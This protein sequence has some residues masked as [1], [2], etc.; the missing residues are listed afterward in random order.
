MYPGHQHGYQGYQQGGYD[1][2]QAHPNH[3]SYQPPS[4][5]PPGPPPG[6]PHH[7]NH[8]GNEQQNP[9]YGGYQDGYG[10]G[11]HYN[12][13]PVDHFSQ[14]ETIEEG[15]PIYQRPPGP[16]PVTRYNQLNFYTANTTSYVNDDHGS[17]IKDQMV[18]CVLL[19][20]A[21]VIQVVEEP[22][23]LC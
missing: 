22:R 16:P 1:G 7:H 17:L 9:Q 23:R 12:P 15:V 2:P 14:R 20:L 6:P 5:P 8:R 3:G 4:G 10:Q 18:T 11:G 13:L 21:V 19:K